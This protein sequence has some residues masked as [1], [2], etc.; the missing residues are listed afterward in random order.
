MI[1]GILVA[2]LVG[3]GAAPLVGPEQAKVEQA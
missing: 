3:A 1:K 2:T